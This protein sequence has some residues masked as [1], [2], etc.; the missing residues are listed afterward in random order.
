MRAEKLQP[1][2]RGRL[3]AADRFAI[4]LDAKHPTTNCGCGLPVLT[5]RFCQYS[6]PPTN[7]AVCCLSLRDRVRHQITATNCGCRLPVTI[8]SKKRGCGPLRPKQAQLLIQYSDFTNRT[9]TCGPFCL[10]K[11]EI[12]NATAPLPKKILEKVAR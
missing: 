4:D 10:C 9:A 12:Q 8:F 2:A 11:A 3:R 1:S 6:F 5:D 7:A